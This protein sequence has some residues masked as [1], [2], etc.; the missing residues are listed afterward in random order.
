MQVIL[1]GAGYATRLYPLT[2]DRPKPLLPIGGVPILERICSALSPIDGITGLHVVTNHV[3]AG[4]F[5]TW[6]EEYRTRLPFETDLQIH[7]DGTTSNEDR[8]G[9]VGDIQFVIDAAGI[10]DDLLVIAGDNLFE[11]PLE[12]VIAFSRDKDSS[13][14]AIREVADREQAKL[15]G[16]VQIDDDARIFDFEEKPADPKSTLMSLGVYYYTR[17]HVPL[18]RKYIDDGHNT[19]APGHFM[20]WFYQQVPLYG[21]AVSGRWF[22][23]GD[24]ASYKEADALYGGPGTGE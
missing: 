1:L 23:I 7:D 19:D 6:A 3:F 21:Y 10:D 15:Y 11:F 9:A 18:I 12:N 5:E 16:I 4:H 24:L 13:G 22:D 17:E 20:Q 14:V 8:L 2:Q